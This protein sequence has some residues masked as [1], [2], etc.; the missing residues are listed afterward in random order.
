[1][2]FAPSDEQQAIRSEIRRLCARFPDA[3]WLACEREHR[4]PEDFYRAVADG[5]WLGV[6]MPEAYGGAG[7]GISEAALV[8]QELAASGGCMAAA[9][10]VHMN[11]FGVN[12]VVRHGT[13]AQRAAHLP[14]VI[15]GHTKVAFG[16]TEPDAGLDTTHISTRAV[17][18]GDG[19]R[20]N[21]RKIW[22]STAQEAD[23][24]LLLARTAPLEA[25]ARP[26]DGLSLF[27]T[28][29]DRSAIDVREIEKCGRA[30]VDSNELFIDNLHVPAG[31]LVGEEGKG[32][33]Y[34]LDG[35]NP[36]RILVA[37][38]AIG[39][40]RVALERATAYARERVVF[41]RPIGQNQA[42]QH[43]LA[44]C[45]AELEAADLITAK[46]AWLYDT[47]QPCGPEANAAKYLGA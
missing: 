13:E 1:M 19:Y 24:L 35:L 3:Y 2:D 44:R 16:V 11:I 8:L 22:T 34:L 37:A 32:F 14:G 47:G 10:A 39:I 31:D 18:E 5:G 6:A 12:P 20:V 41:G 42:I 28:P 38:E 46:A 45:W 25:V 4:F 26:I 43:P 23:M 7:L 29:L 30:A 15:A 21:G 27:F 17:R 33:R 40:G 9:S 36:E